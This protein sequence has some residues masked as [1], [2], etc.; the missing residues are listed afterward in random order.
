MNRQSKREEPVLSSTGKNERMQQEVREHK[1]SREGGVCSRSS[2]LV[3]MQL[4]RSKEA[5]HL[6]LDSCESLKGVRAR[7]PSDQF[8]G[9]ERF[10]LFRRSTV[11]QR[12]GLRIA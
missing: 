1:H 3:K 6:D 8:F 12:G 5:S 7:C 10:A 11:P 2:L 9:R 4:S